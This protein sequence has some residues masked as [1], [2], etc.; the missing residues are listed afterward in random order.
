MGARAMLT[1]GPGIVL[2]FVLAVQSSVYAGCEGQKGRVIFEDD[3]TDN[4]GGWAQDA[5]PGW[6][7]SFAK[8]GLTVHI[9]EPTIN[10]RF[11]NI[12]FTPWLGDFCVEAVMPKPPAA[13]VVARTGLISWQ[14]TS[15][16]FTPSWWEVR[17]PP[18]QSGKSSNALSILMLAAPVGAVSVGVFIAWYPRYR[19][20]NQA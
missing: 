18:A 4:T 7:A 12:T 2:V 20:A 13:H 1:S 8:S 3:F 17:Y 10:V 19:A 9:Q 5:A 14:T 15:P 6:N 11:L 16:T